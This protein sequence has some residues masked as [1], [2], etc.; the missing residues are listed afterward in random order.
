MASR[1]LDHPN[2]PVVVDR[3]F[4]IY[5]G[6]TFFLYAAWAFVSTLEH[7]PTVNRVAS[8]TYQYL[9]S[10]A[11]GTFALVAT[12]FIILSFL[13][14]RMS[15]VTKEKIELVAV[16]LLSGFVSVYPCILLFNWLA[17][18]NPQV[19]AAFFLSLMY[20]LTPL[21]RATHLI[22]RIRDNV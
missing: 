5:F 11:I 6:I 21:Y 12:M 20:I 2:T 8:D 10:G 13:P 9:W 1:F 4:D 22:R 7:I 18:G 14:T 16:I 17:L 19:S 3:K 15:R